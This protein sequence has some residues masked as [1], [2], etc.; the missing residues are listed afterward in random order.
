ME[1]QIQIYAHIREKDHKKQSL[2]EHLTNVAMYSSLLAGKAGL[3]KAGELLGLLHD[4]GKASS[5]FQNYLL[6][7]QGFLNPDA[8][9]Y[10]EPDEMRGKIDHSTAGAQIIFEN[11]WDKGQEERITAQILALCLASHHSGLIDCLTPDGQNYF[12]RRMSKP[13]EETHKSEAS[14]R[15]NE[16]LAIVREKLS[17]SLIDELTN[18]IQHLNEHNNES[19]ETI[20]FKAGL[21]IRFLLSCLIDADRI[22]TSNFEK[23]E[24]KTLRNNGNYLSWTA[25]IDRFN[26]KVEEFK[27]KQPKN[28]VDQLRN[29][30]SQTCYEFS[31]KPKGIYQLTVPTGGGKT[32]AS[33]RFALNHAKH[34]QM[35]RIIYIIPYTSIIDQNAEETR[36]ILEQD[37]GD[38]EYSDQ[39]VLEHHSNLTPELETYRN[40]LLAQNWD[41][42]IVFTTQVQFFEALFGSGTRSLRRM[43]QLAKSVIIM[44][45][46]QTVP[47]QLIHLLNLAIRFLVHSL[48]STVLLCTATQPPLDQLDNSYRSL[49]IKAEQHIIQN[50]QMLFEKLK[51]VEVF[52][53]RK[54]GGWSETEIV[55]LAEYLLTEKGSVLIVVNTKRNAR[56]LYEAIA[57]NKISNLRLFHLSTNMCAAHRLAVLEKVKEG[58]SNRDPVIC[59]STQLIE[60]GVDIDF[61]AVIRYLAGLDSIC[62]SAGRCNRHGIQG[63]PGK[64]WI[65]NPSNEN[66]TPLIDIVIGAEQTLRV[67]DD[68]TKNPSAFENDIIGL[69]AMKRFYRYY[70]YA[71]RKD[72]DYSIK[73]SSQLG[74]ADNMFTLLSTN[75]LAVRAYQ[76]I[77]Q[78]SPNLFFCHAFQSAAKEFQVINN[79]TRGVIVPYQEEGEAIIY[80]LCNDL[81]IDQRQKV[82]KQAQR[83]SINLYQS[84][85]DDLIEKGAIHEIHNGAC[86]FYLEKEFYSDEFGLCE[87]A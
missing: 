38:G 32:F 56:I 36:K 26:K 37:L 76:R 34:H 74:R 45:E 46:V 66:I 65:I 68:F 72:M 3:E 35:D 70:Y 9:D 5:Q 77:H 84:D 44:D 61:G 71:R 87:R 62:Q 15:L 33:L 4:F 39:V 20:L 22:D 86:I 14:S 19:R 54:K 42:P 78:N 11:L 50:E 82:L 21:L 53:R 55:E 67:L 48:G 29:Y 8:D 83:Y 13:D 24:N 10:I 63:Q 79:S 49:T 2:H 30:V 27:N 31:Q 6:S 1:E 23:I 64:V 69:E 18:K 75:A 28:D 25:L 81:A 41:A 16:I 52:D 17:R 59:V 51:R 57:N 47:I 85:F 60:A 58:L 73:S 43:H 7:A 40:N 12:I 80:K